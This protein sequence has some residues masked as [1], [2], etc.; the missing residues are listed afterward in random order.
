[1][2]A[3]EDLE[4]L[5]HFGPVLISEEEGVEKPQSDIFYRACERAGV[6]KNEVVHV[7]DELEWYVRPLIK[8]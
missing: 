4:V 2:S 3:L 1:M 5:S 6:E 7:G 8:T